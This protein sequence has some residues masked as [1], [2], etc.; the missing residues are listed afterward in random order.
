MFNEH[1][2]THEAEFDMNA[3]FEF[4]AQQSF[5]D[6]GR[7]LPVGISGAGFFI[8]NVDE[9]HYLDKHR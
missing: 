3:N 2:Q 4:F 8:T 9:N 1:R 7:R 6:I 5:E